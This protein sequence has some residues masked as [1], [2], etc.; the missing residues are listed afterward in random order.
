MRGHKKGSNTIR[1]EQAG[2][3]ARLFV[4][5]LTMRRLCALLLLML[6]AAAPA[7]AQVQSRPTDAPLVTADNESWYVNREPIPFAGDLF[8]AAG[9]AV[10]FNGNTMVRS[11]HYNGV[12]L[13]TDTTLEPYSIVYVPLERGLMQPYERLRQG[14]VAGTV[15]SRTPSFP[16]RVTTSVTSLPQAAAAPTALSLPIGAI[17]AYTPE[18]PAT[19]VVTAIPLGI[20]TS[21]T[22]TPQSSPVTAVTFSSIGRPT[23]NDG[24]W[25]PYLG[26]KWISA[27]PAIAVTPDDFRVVGSYEGFPVFARRGG[28]EQVIYVATRAGLAAPYRLKQ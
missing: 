2:P 21:G 23:S 24:V 14:S 3:R 18:A 26:E 6:F 27:G 5:G 1:P 11:G 22:A 20:T 4:Y 13:Y 12:P 7:L 8:Y 9:A 28:S 19:G 17:S 16:V 25:I 15:A 10:F